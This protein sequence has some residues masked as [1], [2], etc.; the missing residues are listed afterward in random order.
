MATKPR[1]SALGVAAV[2]DWA[3]RIVTDGRAQWNGGK[4]KG[5]PRPPKVKGRTA[6]AVVT[7][8]RG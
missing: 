6:S 2:V 5:A 8:D 7:N 3:H 4:P 1:I